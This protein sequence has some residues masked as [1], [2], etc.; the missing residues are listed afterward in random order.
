MVNNKFEKG[1]VVYINDST[2]PYEFIRGTI[3]EELK[4]D[5][6][7]C[8]LYKVVD[9]DNREMEIYYPSDF[10]RYSIFTREEWKDHLLSS[11]KNCVDKI[12]EVKEELSSIFKSM[13]ELRETCK[14][15][16][17][18]LT[19][20]EYTSWLVSDHTAP[21]KRRVERGWKRYCKCCF[22]EEKSFTKP[23]ELENVKVKRL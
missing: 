6:E 9:S 12:N 19:D 2:F 7:E 10:M 11:E 4:S 16:G 8:D 15:D 3:V 17:H 20:W 18:I 5:I 13:D 1:Q 22:Y 14:E 21:N 23:K